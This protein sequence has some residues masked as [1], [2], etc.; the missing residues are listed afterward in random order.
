MSSRCLAVSAALMALLALPACER[1]ARDSR[2]KPVTETGPTL[3]SA[4]TTTLYAGDQ[5]PPS[6]DPR[7]KLYEGNAFHVAQGQRWYNWFNCSGCHANGGGGMGPPHIDDEWR[8][9]GNIEQIYAS[10]LQGRPNGMPSFRNKMTEQQIWEVAAYVRSLSGQVSKD[11]ASSR[12]DNMSNTEALTLTE[13][14]PVR[15]SSPASVQGTTP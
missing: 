14:K 13:K 7:G 12:A 4:T 9:G 11:V 8:Y 10:V 15:N 5:P 2:G 6:P 1:E 3:S